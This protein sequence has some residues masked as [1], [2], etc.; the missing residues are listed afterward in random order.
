MDRKGPTRHSAQ[1][2][3]KLVPAGSHKVTGP[4]KTMH[5]ENHNGNGNQ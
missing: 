1:F 4:I 5:K 2:A 3:R